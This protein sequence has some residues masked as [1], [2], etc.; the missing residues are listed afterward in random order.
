MLRRA[1][2]LLAE[3]DR[4]RIVVLGDAV[5][6]S[7]IHGE[8]D[9]V[10]REAPVVVV[11]EECRTQ[12]LGGAANTAHN[13][14]ALGAHAKLVALVG[15]DEAGRLLH[16]ELNACKIDTSHVVRADART[17]TEKI[18]VLAGALHTNKQQML[19]IDREDTEPPTPGAITSIDRCLSPSLGRR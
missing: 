12:S 5:L 18:R 15:D 4:M 9:R 1:R 6:D 19:R 8:T 2:E 10:S 16:R 17:T 11:R 14:V 3:F 13:L 7:Y